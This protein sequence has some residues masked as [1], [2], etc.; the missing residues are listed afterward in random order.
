MGGSNINCLLSPKQ[1]N[2]FLWS[3]KKYMLTWESTVSSIKIAVLSSSELALLTVLPG[4]VQMLSTCTG[5][6]QQITRKL[7]KNC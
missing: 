3:Q 5:R 6:L 1:F 4:P 7:F 2:N